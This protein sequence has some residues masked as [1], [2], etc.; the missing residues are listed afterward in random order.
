MVSQY[1]PLAIRAKRSG[2]AF[3]FF[4]AEND[5]AKIRIDSLGIPIEI[6][7]ILVYHF[8]FLCECAPRLSSRAMAVTGSIDIWPGLMHC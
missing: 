1:H 8:E 4:L 6:A 5:T 2:Q 3:S 7:Y